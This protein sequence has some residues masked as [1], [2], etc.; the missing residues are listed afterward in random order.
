MVLGDVLRKAREGRGLSQKELAGLLDMPP[1][2]YNR[3]E[4]GKTDPSFTTLERI[5]AAL[6]LSLS[7]LFRSE[8]IFRD[9]DSRDKTLLERLRL[10]EEL[11]PAERDSLLTIVDSLVAKKRL[12]D[13]LQ[14]LAKG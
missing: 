1:S 10:M 6:G 13:S 14:N 5:A 9:V 3:I 7:E 12:R 4:G 11:E 2:Q 8:D